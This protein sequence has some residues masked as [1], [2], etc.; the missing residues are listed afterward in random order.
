VSRKVAKV[1]GG[2][3]KNIFSKPNIVQIQVL[4]L[5]SL[6][7]VVFRNFDLLVYSNL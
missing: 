2:I 4:K 1:I 3:T 7:N 6:S 5:L